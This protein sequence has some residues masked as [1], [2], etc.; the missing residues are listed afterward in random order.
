MFDINSWMMSSDNGASGNVDTNYAAVKL[1][2]IIPKGSFFNG[3]QEL[4]IIGT[5]KEPMTLSFD[6]DWTTM[7]SVDVPYVKEIQTALDNAVPALDMS[8]AISLLA[9]GGE[10]G[11]VWKNKQ[12]WKKSGYL[13]LNIKMDIVDWE[14]N[15]IP[16]TMATAMVKLCTPN[17]G[18]THE[19]TLLTRVTKFTDQAGKALTSVLSD[20][21]VVNATG[22]PV[23]RASAEWN[24]NNDFGEMKVGPVPVVVEIGQYFKHPD[25]V[26]KNVV[27]DFSKEVSEF[28]PL[29]AV[30]SFQAESRLLINGMGDVGFKRNTT[31]LN[32]KA[33]VQY[34]KIS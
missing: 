13:K 30:I 17:T 28:G 14:G 10:T 18:T 27:V 22:N 6:S 23:G 26:I 5:L 25:M 1:T 16:L 8:N 7:E 24:S 12:V 9:G 15:G 4:Q 3:G 33:R 29:S 11:S 21:K 31:D 34:G 2:A 19:T 32:G 20:Q